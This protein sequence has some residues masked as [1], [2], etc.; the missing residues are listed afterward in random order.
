LVKIIDV[1]KINRALNLITNKIS[2][3]WVL[4][5]CRG[6]MPYLLFLQLLLAIYIVL[7]CWICEYVFYAA[8]FCNQHHIHSII[9]I[10]TNIYDMLKVLNCGCVVVLNCD[11]L[12]VLNFDMS[13]VLNCGCV[14]VYY[15]NELY[16]CNCVCSWYF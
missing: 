8:L 11:M 5:L 1:S 7:I 10:H 14:V 13:K 6:L 15:I 4:M 3:H 12:K 2:I 9:C 16:G